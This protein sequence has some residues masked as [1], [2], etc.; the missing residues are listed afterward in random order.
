M[1]TP[2]CEK[3]AVFLENITELSKYKNLV[4]KC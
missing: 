1:L 3:E 4:D 2:V